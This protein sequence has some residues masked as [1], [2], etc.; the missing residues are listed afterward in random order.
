M[1]FVVFS[2][3]YDFDF[4]ITSQEIGVEE[5]PRN[6]SLKACFSSPTRT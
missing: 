2:P 6:H 1:L 3:G 4:L 5:R